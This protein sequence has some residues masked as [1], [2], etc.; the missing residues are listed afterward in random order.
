MRAKVAIGLGFNVVVSWGIL[1][2][3]L[4]SPRAATLRDFGEVALWQIIGMVG[5][6][7]AILG[8]VLSFLTQ[9]AVKDLWPILLLLI[10]P[11][12]LALLVY[13]FLLKH[14]ARWA[15]IALHL[16]IAASFAAVWYHH[17][18]GASIADPHPDRT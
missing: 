13:V 11:A 8:G 1:P 3:L 12:M 17:I 7:L 10:Y 2:L 9:P 15:V 16:L 5:W 4:P 14:R 18:E 6:P